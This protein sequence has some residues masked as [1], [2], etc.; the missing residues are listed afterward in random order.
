MTFTNIQLQREN[1]LTDFP[2]NGV[3][4]LDLLAPNDVPDAGHPVG[5]QGEHGHEQGQHHGAVLGVAVQLLQ[6]AQQAQEADRLEQVNQGR[7]GA[8][9]ATWGAV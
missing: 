3:A 2:G 8:E 5:E 7:L 4:A 1:A 9:R 6:Q